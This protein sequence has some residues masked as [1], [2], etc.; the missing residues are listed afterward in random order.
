[1]IKSFLAIIVGIIVDVS[2]RIFYNHIHINQ[3]S[4]IIDN[5]GRN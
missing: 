5:V 2:N 1:M 3:A 4:Q